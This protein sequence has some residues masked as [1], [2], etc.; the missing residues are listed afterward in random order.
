MKKTKRDIHKEIM[1]NKIMPTSYAKKNAD[2]AANNEAPMPTMFPED[3]DINDIMQSELPA[4]PSHDNDEEE[5]E[6][7]ED[8]ARKIDSENENIV[9]ILS[10]YNEYKE[11]KSALKKNRADKKKKKEAEKAET[12][13]ESTENIEKNDISVDIDEANIEDILNDIIEKEGLPKEVTS[14]IKEEVSEVEETSVAEDETVEPEQV[15]DNTDDTDEE[16]ESIVE[17]EN[18]TESV[19]PEEIDTEESEE[20]N[21]DNQEDPESED[22]YLSDIT[23]EEDDYSDIFGADETEEE[24]S[25]PEDEKVSEDIKIINKIETEIFPKIV[26]AK[27]III[28]SKIDEILEKFNCCNCTSCKLEIT[29]HALN[30]LPS[31]YIIVNNE[32]ELNFDITETDYSEITSALIHAIIAI[33]ANPIH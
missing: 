18:I 15:I 11:K 31:E 14:E 24:N 5:K 33:R 16:A 17:D 2:E 22:S 12:K 27:E 4:V 10:E 19:E 7:L 29:A 26:N 23:G 9:K 3:A 25:E 1:Y 28:N 13:S 32:E 6:S 21:T 30:R 20:I 8:I